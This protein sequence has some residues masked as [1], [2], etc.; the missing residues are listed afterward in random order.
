MDID[1][2]VALNNNLDAM[3]SQLNNLKSLGQTLNKEIEEQD[4]ILDRIKTKTENVDWKAKKQNTD[5][6]KF[7]N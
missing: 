1:V 5:M 6:K 2:D 7:L 3:S 4:P